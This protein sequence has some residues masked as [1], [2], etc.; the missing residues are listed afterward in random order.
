M[1]ALAEDMGI[2]KR[3][4]YERFKDKD[5]LLLEVIRYYQQ[6]TKENAHKLI[7]QS[8]NALVDRVKIK[9]AGVTD[10]AGFVDGD[11]ERREQPHG[12]EHEDL[13]APVDRPP[14]LAQLERPV[15]GSAKR[16]REV[17]AVIGRHIPD[18]GIAG[19]SFD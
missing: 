19:P 2:S 6:Q 14:D 10:L 4:I 17:R 18:E 15:E 12:T 13:R 9:I 7:D 1:D 16:V 5:T 11:G 3:T 8:D